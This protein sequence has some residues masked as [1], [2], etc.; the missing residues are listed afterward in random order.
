MIGKSQRHR[1]AWLIRA[2]LSSLVVCAATVISHSPAHAEVEDDLR[3][4]DKLFDEGAWKKAAVAY[5]RAIRKYPGQ[6]SAAAFGKRAAI[7]I[8]EKDY[9]GG[10][11]FVQSSKSQFPNS[12]EIG[13]QEALMLWALDKKREAVTVAEKVVVA[14]P[15]AF[16]NQ[17][18]IG[19]F[20]ATKDP[21][22][23]ITAYEAYLSSRPE[24]LEANDVLPRIRLGFA[25]L[26]SARAGT[27]DDAKAAAMFSKA[28]AQFDVVQK[29]HAK[30][31]HAQINADSG[32]CAAYTGL[33]KFDQAI[34][35]CERII[36]DNR[37]IDSTGAV[38]YNLG[39]AYL[40]KK[41]IRK[42]RSAASE[43]TRVRKNEASGFILIGDTF[44][45]DRDWSNALEQ[46]LRAEK[47]IRA[48]QTR[49]AVQL[50]IRL[51]KTYRRLPGTDN[52]NSPNLQ[53]AIDKL[54]AGLA[55]TPDNPDL[56]AELG[57]AYLAGHQD[58]KVSGLTDRFIGGANFAKYSPEGR[59]ALLVLAGKACTDSSAIVST[60]AARSQ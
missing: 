17:K 32:L 20:Y 44:Y 51:G 58:A 57:S 42:A 13:E 31:P 47:M 21:A 25:L 29:K 38:W 6:V 34:T 27:T 37:R 40:A 24:T 48:G 7:F 12:P 33:G 5:D 43:F 41:Q 30:R 36:S 50:S 45:E 28:A 52:P 4:G 19:E 10:V 59:A 9:A 49:D 53:L 60:A 18:I 23:T 1:T 56:A 39:T 15:R 8:I 55:A 2:A 22:R 16:T 26:A 35:V 46:Y 54:S 11:V 3:E 14:K